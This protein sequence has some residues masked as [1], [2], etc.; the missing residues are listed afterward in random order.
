ARATTSTASGAARI[1]SVGRD[2]KAASTAA[3]TT[4]HAYRP[5]CRSR[6]QHGRPHRSFEIDHRA[7]TLPFSVSKVLPPFLVGVASGSA[8][9][10]PS[11]SLRLGPAGPLVCT[12]CATSQT[13]FCMASVFL[14]PPFNWSPTCGGIPHFAALVSMYLIIL[15]SAWP[16]F[17]SSLHAS[18]GGACRSLAALISLPRFSASSRSG[19]NAFMQASCA[20][21]ACGA[22]PAGGRSNCVPVTGAAPALGNGEA[23]AGGAPSDTAGAAPFTGGNAGSFGWTARPGSGPGKGPLAVERP[24]EPVTVA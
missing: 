9:D 22:A 6:R 10:E 8:A 17:A 21:P 15:S 7:S 1:R 3:T 19:M 16:K 11:T 18:A 13:F 12:C 5:S 14:W 23:A 2:G 24:A 20:P 4:A